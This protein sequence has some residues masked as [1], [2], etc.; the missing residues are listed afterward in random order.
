M[1]QQH[2]SGREKR[3]LQLAEEIKRLKL[4]AAIKVL[5]GEKR[6]H[7]NP[8]STMVFHFLDDRQRL[9]VMQDFPEDR[10][11]LFYVNGRRRFIAGKW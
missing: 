8:Y 3:I 6:F 2:L 10:S 1:Q 11:R 4:P 9:D 7:W 5:P